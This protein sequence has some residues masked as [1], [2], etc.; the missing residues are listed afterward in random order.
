[1]GASKGHGGRSGALV[2]VRSVEG[3]MALAEVSM[4]KREKL[5]FVPLWMHRYPL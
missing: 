4:G 5:T 3:G 1:M 2:V